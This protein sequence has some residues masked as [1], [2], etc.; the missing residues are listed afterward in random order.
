[1]NYIKEGY[2]KSFEDLT[3][4]LDSFAERG[5]PG[6]DCAVYHHGELVYRHMNG[7][8]DFESKT[9]VKGD[10]L[11]NIYSCSKPL[12]C[13]AALQL[14]EKGLFDLDD[15][16]CKY[17]PEFENMTICDENGSRP[18]K[19]KITIRQL[20]TMTAGF[21]YDIS[22]DAIARAK[23]DTDGK[24][25]TLKTIEYM[26]DANLKFEPGAAWLYSLCHDILGGLIEKLSG[27][28]LN[29]YVSENIFKPLG[30]TRTTYNL[31][32]EKLDEVA[33]QYTLNVETKELSNCGKRTS[34][35][36]LGSQYHSGGA[37][38]VTCMDDYIKFIEALR[39][40]DIILKNE[41]IDIMQTNQ[42][43]D[44]QMISYKETP[45]RG[46]YGYGLGVR[47]PNTEDGPQDFGWGGAAGSYIAI[48]RKLDYTLF[49]MQHVF[50]SPIPDTSEKINISTTVRK[51][52]M[53]M[54]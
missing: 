52:I 49:Y 12:T 10:E 8:S 2:E 54:Q 45:G 17:M 21:D 29:E 16:L 5:V 35:Y 47:C 41:T 15:P 46:P 19:N 53:S 50:G 39:K 31:P 18:A 24:C 1:M 4:L 9:P 20:F 14:Y 23:K 36:K 38:I 6:N 37:G 51:C 32:D 34:C 28:T 3:A 42:L 13:T 11:Y 40:G 33:S 30:M 43:N 26:G 22:C 44:E 25:P 48:D 27:M 7:Y